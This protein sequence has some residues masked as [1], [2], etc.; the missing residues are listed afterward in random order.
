MISLADVAFIL[1]IAIS[2]EGIGKNDSNDTGGSNYLS[3]PVIV[4]KDDM[5]TEIRLKVLFGDTISEDEP[6]M[7][8]IKNGFSQKGSLNDFIARSNTM[9]LRIYIFAHEEDQFYRVKNIYDQLESHPIK[10]MDPV[11]YNACLD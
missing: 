11:C 9:N 2:L 4:R 7:W 3:E 10:I 1:L 6:L 8:K 5:S